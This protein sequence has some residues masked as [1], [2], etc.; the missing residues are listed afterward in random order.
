MYWEARV[1]QKVILKG[2]AI[3]KVYHGDIAEITHYSPKGER[4]VRVRIV[5]SG[6]MAHIG[7]GGFAYKDEL[8][9]PV[10]ENNKAAKAFLRR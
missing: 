7:A 2:G 6:N 8:D 5:S 9:P 3:S 4:E 10:C 1:G